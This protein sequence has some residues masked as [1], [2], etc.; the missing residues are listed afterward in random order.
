MT[1]PVSTS[2]PDAGVST[3]RVSVTL[4]KPHTH[5]G[6]ELVEGDTL[7]LLPDQAEWLVGLGVAAPSSKE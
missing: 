7:S 4:L 5:E 6:V 3:A 1:K 2:S